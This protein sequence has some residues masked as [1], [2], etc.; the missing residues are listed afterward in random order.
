MDEPLD[1]LD[2]KWRAA[3]RVVI[4]Q[5]VGPLKD[6]LEWLGTHIEQPKFRKSSFSGK[7]VAYANS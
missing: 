5:E 7:R 6:Y 2:R 1:T 4:G 3:C